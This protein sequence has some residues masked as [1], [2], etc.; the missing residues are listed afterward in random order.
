MKKWDFEVMYTSLQS[1]KM[2]KKDRWFNPF[3]SIWLQYL[4]SRPS[5]YECPFTTTE[6]VADIT[7]G[8][9]WGVHIYCPELYGEN[10]GASLIVVNT[11]KGAA[12]LDKSKQYL[13]GHELD[14]D[15]AL[16]ENWIPIFEKF[17][18]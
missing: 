16:K 11:E 5:C 13:Y 7:L 1:G 3:W 14:F 18:P 6:R 8:D 2:L 10:G 4:M 15:T 17:T 9:L 12:A